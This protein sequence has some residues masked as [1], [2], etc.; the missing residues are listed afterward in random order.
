M[1]RWIQTVQKRPWL[2]IAV[3]LVI[4][5]ALGSFLPR[6]E[7]D[8]SI[9][10]MIPQDDPVLAELEK[11]VEDFGSQDLFFIALESDNVFQPATMRKIADMTAALEKV[12]GVKAVENPFNVQMVESSYFGIEIAPHG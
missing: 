4:T 9:E 11:A 5:A 8:A 12:P 3:V 10:A 1:E 6:L 2:I 7:F